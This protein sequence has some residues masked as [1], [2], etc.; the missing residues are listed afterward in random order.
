MVD[1]ILVALAMFLAWL[2]VRSRIRRGPQVVNNYRI[3]PGAD[4]SGGGSLRGGFERCTVIWCEPQGREPQ[5]SVAHRCKARTGEPGWCEPQRGV[6][7]RGDLIGADLEGAYLEGA[8]LDGADLEG[9]DLEGAYLREAN[10]TRANALGGPPFKV[11]GDENWG[12]G[13]PLAINLRWADLSQANFCGANLGGANLKGANLRGAHFT[14]ADLSGEDL[15]GAV[16]GSAWFDRANLRGANLA[17][18]EGFGRGMGSVTF[19][20]AKADQDTVWP[21][22]FDPVV[23]EVIFD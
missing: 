11:P 5:R 2:W 18:T 21:N 19:R 10:L 9:A 12:V 23:S 6:P 7:H 14:K 15:S 13:S 8:N 16:L 20:L 3:K 1:L 22:W 4:L 17:G